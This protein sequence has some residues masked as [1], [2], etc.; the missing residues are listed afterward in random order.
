M[1]KSERVPRGC[2]VAR[3]ATWQSHA[4]PLSAY[5]AR[6]IYFIYIT[7]SIRGFWPPVYREGIRPLIPSGLINPTDRTNFFRVGQSHT[8]SFDAGDVAII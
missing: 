4:D 1:Q 5:V 7:F 2:D 3:K 8:F 6:I